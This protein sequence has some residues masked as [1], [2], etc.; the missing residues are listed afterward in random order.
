M[1]IFPPVSI[2]SPTCSSL[3]YILLLPN[4]QS[5]GIRMFS[6]L[7]VS[8]LTSLLWLA[9][10]LG[11]KKQW[12]MTKELEKVKTNRQ[13]LLPLQIERRA[14]DLLPAF[15]M[16]YLDCM[17]MILKRDCNTFLKKKQLFWLE[18]TGDLNHGGRQLGILLCFQLYSR[19]VL[20]SIKFDVCFFF[21]SS[22]HSKILLYFWLLYSVLEHNLLGFCKQFF[23]AH[24]QLWIW[25]GLVF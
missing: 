25:E 7:Y 19:C 21:L 17:E 6:P 13:V 14:R 12:L 22:L 18:W 10:V 5:E 15:G 2:K 4:T 8:V 24:L 9:P 3:A 20:F 16:E 23:I 11:N 1:C